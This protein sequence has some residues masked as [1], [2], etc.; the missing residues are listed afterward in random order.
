[1]IVQTPDNRF[2]AV[3]FGIEYNSAAFE[4]PFTKSIQR[5]EFAGARWVAT[6]TPIIKSLTY[7]NVELAEWKAFLV[8]TRGMINEFYVSDPTAC[9]NDQCN[10]VGEYIDSD[11]YTIPPVSGSVPQLYPTEQLYPSSS[12]YPKAQTFT[13]YVFKLRL[14]VVDVELSGNN[15]SGTTAN[16]CGLISLSLSGGWDF[17]DGVNPGYY[18]EYI[19]ALKDFDMY[20]NFDI[21][22]CIGTYF[23][24][25]GELKIITGLGDISYP[26]K[27]NISI[28][29]IYG[30][31]FLAAYWDEDTFELK[32]EVIGVGGDSCV[33]SDPIYQADYQGIYYPFAANV[34]VWQGF[35]EEGGKYYAD[36]GE[37]NLLNPQ[38]YMHYQDAA[39]NYA[40]S[41]INEDDSFWSLTAEYTITDLGTSEIIP[42]QNKYLNF[43]TDSSKNRNSNIP[44]IISGNDDSFLAIVEQDSSPDC[45]MRVRDNILA[46][47][48]G[49]LYIT[50][51][52]GIISTTIECPYLSREIR[53]GIWMIAMSL[54]SV[55]GD[56]FRAYLY[57][58]RSTSNSGTIFHYAAVYPDTTVAEAMELG[59]ILSDGS[60]GVSTDEIINTWAA[61]NNSNTQGVYAGN[62]KLTGSDQVL[63]GL[64]GVSVLAV[65]GSDIVL[66]D[67]TNSC[68]VPVVSDNPFIQ[69][70]YNPTD[71]MEL[72]VDSVL[73]SCPYDGTLGNGSISV[74]SSISGLE[75]SDVVGKKIQLRRGGKDCKASFCQEIT[76]YPPMRGDGNVVN[77][78]NPKVLMRMVDDMQAGW[79]SSAA[80]NIVH[81][82]YSCVEVFECET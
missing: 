11:S 61:A 63:L 46:V 82:S 56:D 13:A 62:Y 19:N 12:L 35:R 59:V 41:Y 48:L 18:D 23:N 54:S 49:D 60:V 1:M 76:F 14:T 16:I 81:M 53:P 8:S 5:L 43:T 2:M 29:K 42:E 69:F 50:F 77:I 3:D 7:N 40:Q 27:Y 47:D 39:T 34:P 4:S 36:D 45:R 28:D 26:D 74:A 66:S 72:N 37:G 20:S 64:G 21:P 51:A 22:L 44:N 70:S 73:A 33:H 17:H 79:K 32:Q 52:T 15:V 68:S 67:S 38:P 6:L 30:V 78:D 55:V 57:A 10:I 58:S 80:D 75:R 65:V 71:G 24:I 9:N 25:G 31:V